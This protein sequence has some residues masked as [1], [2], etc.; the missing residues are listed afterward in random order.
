MRCSNCVF[1]KCCAETLAAGNCPK[2]IKEGR[3]RCI[4]CEKNQTRAICDKCIKDITNEKELK[5]KVIDRRIR[6]TE[7]TL[8]LGEIPF[9]RAF[10]F[11]DQ[12]KPYHCSTFIKMTVCHTYRRGF[13]N[14]QNQTWAFDV[15][16]GK[17][18][19]FGNGN[20]VRMLEAEFHII[21]EIGH[22]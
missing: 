14:N 4:R 13:I 6:D 7:R 10:E 9:N 21:G 12:R 20:E 11:I 18:C 16:K 3:F 22:G 2:L 15:Q 8:T 5:M 1:V 19:Q 17:L